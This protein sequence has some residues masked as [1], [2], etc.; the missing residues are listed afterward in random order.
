MVTRTIDKTTYVVGLHFKE[1]LVAQFKERHTRNRNARVG[2]LEAD[3]TVLLPRTDS[4]GV[5]VLLV[6]V[7]KNVIII[8]PDLLLMAVV[9]TTKSNPPSNRNKKQ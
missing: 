3:H 5:H 7:V 9:N 6:E 8:L 4:T 1:G 2:D